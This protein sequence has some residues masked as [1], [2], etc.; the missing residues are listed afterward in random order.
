MHIY[1]TLIPIRDWIKPILRY[2][3]NCISIENIVVWIL[4]MLPCKKIILKSLMQL[5]F[6]TPFQLSTHF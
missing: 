5:E 1:D 3:L 4:L 6:V 2:V